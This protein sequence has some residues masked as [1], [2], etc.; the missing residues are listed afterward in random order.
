MSPFPPCVPHPRRFRTSSAF[1]TRVPFP[2]SSASRS[3]S[4]C[5]PPPRCVPPLSCA[6]SRSSFTMCVSPCLLSLPS[7]LTLTRRRISCTSAL[8][9][10]PTTASPTALQL[11]LP[12]PLYPSYQMLTSSLR[13]RAVHTP[14]ACRRATHV[15]R[16]RAQ[17]YVFSP[18]HSLTPLSFLPHL[19]LSPSS[20]FPPLLSH[21]PFHPLLVCPHSL[22]RRFFPPKLRTGGARVRVHCLRRATPVPRTGAPPSYVPLDSSFISTNA[23]LVPTFAQS[24]S[25]PPAWPASS[26]ASALRFN[27]RPPIPSRDYRIFPPITHAPLCTYARARTAR[28]MLTPPS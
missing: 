19:P 12:P 9:S 24:T 11:C 5:C 4:P 7:S 26:C 2:A 16:H 14:L 21:F 28:P 22:P 3:I 6:A 25:G 20:R 18:T 8:P 1:L 10:L 23:D 15:L 27:V 13:K 17:M